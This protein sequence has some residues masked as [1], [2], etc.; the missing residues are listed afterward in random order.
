MRYDDFVAHVQS[1]AALAS[2]DEAVRAIGAT[3]RT[4]GERLLAE[5]AHRL[6]EELPPELGR[7]L[8]EVASGQEFDTDGFFARVSEREGV[9]ISEATDHARVV[10]EVLR[11]AVPP[12]VIDRVQTRLRG[13]YGPLFL[14]V[15]KGHTP[16]GRR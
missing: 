9:D 2:A 14:G 7:Y 6:A 5:D 8:E 15:G 11:R 13:Q 12:G 10:L 3:L 4:L 1:R 16:G